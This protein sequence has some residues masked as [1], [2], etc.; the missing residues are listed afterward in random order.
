M[1]LNINRNLFAQVNIDSGSLSMMTTV[2]H[3][4]DRPGNYEC[5]VTQRDVTSRR[6]AIMVAEGGPSAA[7]QSQ[8][9]QPFQPA[10][11][12]INLKDTA[13]DLYT[14]KAGGY[15]VF[16]VSAGSGYA[17]EVYRS[18][19][20]VQAKVF[21]SRELKDGD[22]LSALVIRPGT[23]SVTNTINNTKAELVVNYPELGK[24]RR[25]LPPVNVECTAQGIGQGRIQI[26]P[27]QGLVFTCRV[28]S[29]IKIELA[30]PEDRPSRLFKG[31]VLARREKAGRKI[32]RKYRLMP[33]GGT[34]P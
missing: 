12:S 5:A 29:R 30:R 32:V 9:P 10:Q 2:V 19:K 20:G 15:A 6:F 21:D 22:V 27:T 23:Y 14:L 25:N 34:Q 11:V 3:R 17:V 8:A 24:A 1:N 7:M 13:P 26:D 28:P 18:E 31:R 4:F 33:S 16:H